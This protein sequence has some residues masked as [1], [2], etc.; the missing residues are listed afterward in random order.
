M[1]GHERHAFFGHEEHEG[2]ERSGVKNSKENHFKKERMSDGSCG[3]SGEK[4]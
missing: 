2:E 1:S 3:L 4:K